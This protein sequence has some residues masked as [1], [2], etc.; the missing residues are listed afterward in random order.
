MHLQVLG[1]GSGGN[2]VLVRAGE[3]NLLVDAGLPIDE[4][5]RRLDEARLP[6]H[7]L[8][9]IALTH[10]HLDHARSAGLLSRKCGARVYCSTAVMANASLR[11]ARAFHALSVGGSVVVKSRRGHDELLLHAIRLP[12]DCDPTLAFRLEHAGRRAAIC[13]D[14]GSPER[15]AAE[16]L[17]G[18]HLLLLEFNHDAAMLA[19][20]PYSSALKRRVAGPRGHLSNE[21]AAQV[22]RWATG[23]ELGTL[24]LAHLSAVNNRPDLALASARAALAEVGRSDVQLLV[25]EQQRIGPLLAV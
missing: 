2:A 16:A 15:T 23:P 7:R 21:Q 17:A 3:L 18:A 8:D 1:S 25:A 5:E 24:V 10:G 20:G 12:H 19:Q 11:N 4:L 14:M 22:L 13:T 6:A 9:A